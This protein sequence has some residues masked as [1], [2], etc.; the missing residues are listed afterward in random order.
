MC[1]HH[2]LPLQASHLD[3]ARKQQGKGE[4]LILLLCHPPGLI[5]FFYYFFPHPFFFPPSA[6]NLGTEP[7]ATLSEIDARL[8]A[9][10]VYISTLGTHT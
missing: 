10:Q 7:S 4:P 1:H 9:L 8:Q 5:L 6:E 2:P 3:R